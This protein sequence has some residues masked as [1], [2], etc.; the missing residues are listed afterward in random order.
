MKSTLYAYLEGDLRIVDIENIYTVFTVFAALILTLIPTYLVSLSNVYWDTLISIGESCPGLSSTWGNSGAGSLIYNWVYKTITC[1][2]I[3]TGVGAALTVIFCLL[4]VVFHP[5]EE[6]LFRK[7]W[8]K[9]GLYLT[10]LYLL[11]TVL[12]MIGTLC[13]FYFFIFFFALPSSK[14]CDSIVALSHGQLSDYDEGIVIGTM[15]GCSII[16]GIT[17]LMV[18]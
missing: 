16:I 17:G 9:K 12:Y 2:F 1:M 18:W 8:R 4:F 15:L 6:A 11:S 10:C 3:V 5:R 7:W 13:I 14:L